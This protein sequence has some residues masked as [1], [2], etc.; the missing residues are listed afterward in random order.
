[1]K[2]KKVSHLF[3]A[4]LE[5]RATAELLRQPALSNYLATENNPR[6]LTEKVGGRAAKPLHLFK[7]KRHSVVFKYLTGMLSSIYRYSQTLLADHRRS[8][9]SPL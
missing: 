6:G 3:G 5:S 2:S 1:M 4:D 8:S 9:S 7:D